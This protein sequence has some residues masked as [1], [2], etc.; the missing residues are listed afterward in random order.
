MIAGK[1]KV[2]I[3][4]EATDAGVGRHVIDLSAGLGQRGHDVHTLYSPNRADPGLV[5]ELHHSVGVKPIAIDINRRPGLT[6][7]AA[8]KRIRRYMKRHGP[9]DIVHGQSTKGAIGCIAA[10]GFSSGR[11]LTPHAFRS[12]DTRLP[13][14][15]RIA[16]VAIERLLA[17]FAHRVITVSPVERA[18]AE[19]YGIGAGKLSTVIN[20]V[21]A[22]RGPD[23]RAA[24]RK[25]GLRTDDIAIGFV[26]RLASQK[27]P[28]RL[29]E[30][31]SDVASTAH[32]ACLVI[33]GEGPLEPELR[34][35]AEKR[36]IADRVIWAGKANG[37][38]IMTALDIFAL[39][40]AYEAMPYVLLEAA[41]AGLPIVVT[42]IGGARTVVAP[43]ASGFIVPNWDRAAFAERLGELVDQ[44]ET[45]AHMTKIARAR[46]RE[47]GIDRMIEETL[48]VYRS[49]IDAMRTR[50]QTAGRGEEQ[51]SA[52]SAPSRR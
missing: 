43:G 5:E 45:R 8:I 38:E 44:P 34:A 27:A 33:S 22:Y 21:P 40:S 50:S 37:R 51:P 24:R 46:S 25:L 35:L 12:M 15:K 23:R 31:F 42:D 10:L 19:L 18:H 13:G 32:N 16:I 39:C 49:T 1:M 2:L 47:F 36:A 26:G 20:G 28:D 14:V 4:V 3:V 17:R 7:F 11:I 9:F 48:I 29:I 52:Q 41:A 6:D 30:A